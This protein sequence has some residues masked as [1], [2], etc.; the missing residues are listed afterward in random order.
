[1][2]PYAESLLENPAYIPFSIYQFYHTKKTNL[3]QQNSDK[4]HQYGLD[5][6]F[7]WG[8]NK[9]KCVQPLKNNDKFLFEVE[10]SK[11]SPWGRHTDKSQF[12]P[13]FP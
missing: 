9:I 12:T 1:M 11:P 2:F 13:L 10:V 3:R 8:Y 7:F 4:N 6:A 5:E